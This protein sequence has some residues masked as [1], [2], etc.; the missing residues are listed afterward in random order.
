MFTLRKT[1]FPYVSPFDPCPPITCKEYVTPPNLYINFQPQG[2]QQFHPKE[3]L[4]TGTL[5]PFFYDPYFNHHELK[6]REGQ[7]DA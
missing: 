3:A 2:L 1:Y 6:L 4:R 5:W 7:S